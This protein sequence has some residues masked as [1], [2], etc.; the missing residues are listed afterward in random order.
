[1]RAG[2]DSRRWHPSNPISDN[3]LAPDT[4]TRLPR[5]SHL[6]RDRRS[7]RAT[8]TV[9]SGFAA[10]SLAARERPPVSVCISVAEVGRGRLGAVRKL[11]QR[12]SADHAI[13]F[14][15]NAPRPTELLSILIRL[16][17]FSKAASLALSGAGRH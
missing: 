7:R 6:P 11:S 10:N 1:M 16:I 2:L 13:K 15:R 9:E 17:S 3:L 8:R 12:K 4:P 14:C 5:R